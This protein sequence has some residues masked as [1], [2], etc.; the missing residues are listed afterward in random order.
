MSLHVMMV[1]AYGL[2]KSFSRLDLAS[3]EIPFPPNMPSLC[4]FLIQKN[5]VSTFVSYFMALVSRGI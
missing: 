2:E 1:S 4:L 3:S 5:L